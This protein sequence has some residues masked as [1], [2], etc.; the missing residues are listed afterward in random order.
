MK[1]LV[2]LA[3]ILVLIV[4]CTDERPDDA[5]VKVPDD[6]EDEEIK[7]NVASVLRKLD[8]SPIKVGFV[9]LAAYDKENDL[10]YVDI[11][12]DIEGTL[13]TLRDFIKKSLG[14]AIGVGYPT[15]E[16]IGFMISKAA[17]EERALSKVVEEKSGETKEGVKEE[18]TEEKE[19]KEIKEKDTSDSN[20]QDAKEEEQWNTYM[21][22]CYFIS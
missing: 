1:I 21:R 2:F 5:V 17:V 13:E 18:K 12:I 15:K 8:V 10:V 7:E 11:A 20:K 19:E 14:F 9:P 4:G 22:L 3:V 6:P 16:T